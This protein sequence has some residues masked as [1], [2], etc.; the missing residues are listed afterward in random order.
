M[1]GGVP[2]HM[3]PSS[4]STWRQSLCC[5]PWRIWSKLDPELPGILLSQSPVTDTL[6]LEICATTSSFPCRALNSSPHVHTTSTVL[7]TKPSPLPSA[8]NLFVRC[9]CYYII[10]VTVLLCI[11]LMSYFRWDFPTNKQESR[12]TRWPQEDTKALSVVLWRLP[13]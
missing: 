7:P 12:V 9:G 10:F 3:Y 2:I 1:R 11:C 5:L 6:G 8:P 4:P 13:F